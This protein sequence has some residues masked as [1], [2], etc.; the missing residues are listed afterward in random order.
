MKTTILYTGMKYD[1]GDKNRGLSFEHR[2]FYAPLRSYCSKMGWDFVHY[3]FME[4]GKQIG[5]EA[6]SREL[7][8]VCA[9]VKPAFLFAVLF[10]FHTDPDKEVFRKI[11]EMGTITFHWF[12]DD[13]WRFDKFSSVIAPYF[14][15]AATTAESALPKYE[16]LG[17]RDRIIKTQW[18]CNH[19]LYIPYA[20]EK[21]IP[22]S[23]IGQPHGSRVDTLKALAEK[24]IATEV[25][26]FGWKDR[27][28][29]PFHQMVRMFSRSKI[30][31]NLSNAS[32]QAQSQ[33]KGRNFEI[34]GTRSFL[35]SD[36]ADNIEAYYTPGKEIV[37]FSSV[38]ELAE[39]TKYYLQHEDERNKIAEAAYTRTLAEHTWHHRFEEIFRKAGLIKQSSAPGTAPAVSVIIPCYNQAEFLED[40]VSSVVAQT[41]SD[42]ELLI[43][44]DGSPDNTSEVAKQLIA[45]YGN[46]TIKLLEK[47]NGGL[48][49]ARNYGI[50]H[51]RGE[52]ILPL[53]SDD[54]IAPEY[55]E[56]AVAVLR[57]QPKVSIVYVNEQNF[58]VYSHIHRKGISSLPNLLYANVHDYCTMYRREVWEKTGG[59]SPAMYL[60]GEDWNYWITASKL[61]CISYHL[62]EPLFL[63]RARE[64]TM[65]AE[66]LANINEVYAHIILHH[67]ELF[68]ETARQNA[69]LTLSTIPENNLNKLR[70][71]AAKHPSHSLLARLVQLGELKKNEPRP[72]ELW[73]PLFSVV[74]PSYNRPHGVKDVII[75]LLN[76]QCVNFEAIFVNDAGESPEPLIRAFNDKRL[77]CVSHKENRGLP[78]ARNTGISRARGKYIAYLDD[79]DIYYP[80]HLSELYKGFL[81]S[82]K[83]I[84]Y[85]NVHRGWIGSES[86]DKQSSPAVVYRDI[87]YNFEFSRDRFLTQNYMPVL[88]VSHTRK[89]YDELGGFDETFRAHEDWELWCRYSR[90][91]EFHHI[92]EV[93]AEFRW[94]PAG[95]SMTNTKRDAFFTTMKEIF[96]R[97]FAESSTKPY[98][99][100]AQKQAYLNLKNEVT[101]KSKK[102]PLV[103]VII[104]TFNKYEF[105]A[106]CIASIYRNTAPG[107]FEV[108]I[109]DNGSTDGTVEALQK[110]AAE[111]NGLRVLVNG[112]NLG[113]SKANNKALATA[114][115]E[116]VVFLN[117]D[118]EPLAGWLPPLI[119]ILKT[120]AT[121]GAVGSK[122]LFPD[123]T[124]QHA[125]VVIADET[126]N[127]DP[128]VA[129]HRYYGGDAQLPEANILYRYQALTAACICMRTKDARSFGGFDEGFW[130]G[131]EDVDLCFRIAAQGMICVYQ[132]ASVVVHHESKS[133]AQRFIKVKENINRLHS[134]WLGKVRYDVIGTGPG[135]S[136]ETDEPGFGPYVIPLTSIV[137]PLFNGLEYTKQCIAALREHTNVPYEIILVD[138]NSSDG[139]REYLYD[140][141][142]ENEDITVIFNS[143]NKGF[144]GGVNDGIN[145][146]KGSY[147]LIANND[148]IVTPGWLKRMREVA[149]SDAAIGIVGGV[150]NFVSGVQRDGEAVYETVPEMFE[151][152]K[153]AN[154]KRKG[155]IAKFPRV[156]FLCTLIKR[157]VINKIG[158][159]DER[160]A[161]GNFEDDDFCLR[162]QL[163]GY[164]TV[165]ALDVFIHHFG[166]KSFLA[167]GEEKYRARLEKNRQIF[168]AK[169][170]GDPDEIWLQGKQ[171]L[172]R[173]I[174]IPMDVHEPFHY[175]KNAYASLQ[176]N[177]ASLALR[178]VNEGSRSAAHSA[179]Q[180]KEL[181]NKL[182]LLQSKL[183][184]IANN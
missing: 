180:D 157:E 83:E 95:S 46:Y 102:K 162:A 69:E 158:G 44:N 17:I 54:A 11:S 10:D 155:K 163:A 131:Y 119:E 104:P 62:D 137:I 81:I 165:I 90:K 76:Q 22:V 2:N 151:Y 55:L 41:F 159:L 25:Y 126:V 140:L 24:G 139:T 101:G 114:Q 143:A 42:W 118:T 152:V 32:Q 107:S 116:Y 106:K 36:P 65:V 103:S 109:S 50:K 8:A 3:D 148:I 74:V 99:L 170:G 145:A 132:P 161:P 127:G 166:S 51:S 47:P 38:E 86:K 72:E 30:N 182:H 84:V 105:T 75:S 172:Q 115:G 58:G 77:R 39:K 130:N 173:S 160:F 23:F 15:L 117:N 149:G 91:Y 79:D 59:Y 60:G 20:C 45:R 66:T 97:H 171:P 37:L 71:V 64:N 40:A 33:I 21:D 73:E 179:Y 85:T 87:P 49:D 177:D 14:D 80:N 113:F 27:P 129:K 29:L 12:C 89:V 181:I 78:A 184:A 98:V 70:K 6:M 142:L 156:A 94:N 168:I 82:G 108:I 111:L 35:L 96:V 167:N 141:Y 67:P 4:R 174:V 133:G 175:L 121:V 153:K 135:E 144:P 53:D 18:A 9:D 164:T 150:S 56:K 43:V 34:P 5:R 26:G 16:Q 120:D 110:L 93:T 48:A 146:A 100:A 183:E 147:I 122:L 138:N 123:G 28:R 19:E 92:N 7:L 176:E 57:S 52:F 112:E 13:H 134:R 88:A 1:Y 31:L 125:G 63:Y 169:W 124:L 61:G 128:L 154:K 136:K 178:Y 68:T